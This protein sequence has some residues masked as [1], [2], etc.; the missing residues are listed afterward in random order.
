VPPIAY[1]GPESVP[2]FVLFGFV[3]GLLGVAY[4]RAILRALG[5]MERFSDLPVEVRAA[6]VGAAVGLLA[7]FISSWVGG[8]DTLTQSTL[9]GEF[10]GQC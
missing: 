2:L 7:W 5:A 9:L 4:S 1:V 6:L 3:V 8:G 10:G